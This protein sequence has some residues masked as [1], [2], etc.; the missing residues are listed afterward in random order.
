MVENIWVGILPTETWSLHP[1]PDFRSPGRDIWARCA[2]GRISGWEALWEVANPIPKPGR[3][4]PVVPQLPHSFLISTEE[5]RPGPPTPHT[6]EL[7]TSQ[8]GP[9]Q[10]WK[11]LTGR[12]SLMV[13]SRN[14]MPYN[15]KQLLMF[16][17][18]KATQNSA[19]PSCM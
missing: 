1:M 16:L 6:K 17:F 8:D 4:W 18:S 2:C 10:L 7:T 5:V 12:N 19:N 11:A 14:P 15:F 13:L 3:H 9:G